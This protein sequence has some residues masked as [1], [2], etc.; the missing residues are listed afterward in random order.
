MT[1]ILGIVVLVEFIWL[2]SLQDSLGGLRFKIKRLEKQ[3][4]QNPAEADKPAAAPAREASVSPV[5]QTR[6]EPAH[7]DSA[8]DSKRQVLQ[9]SPSKPDFTVAKL[10]SWIGGFTLLLGVIFWIKYAIENDL[11][12]P[13][14]RIAASI[15][16]GVGLWTAGALIKK[17]ALKTTSDTLCASGLCICYAAWFSAYYFYQML[18]Q[19]AVFALLDLTALAAFGTAV[20]RRAKYIGFLA[21][22]IGFL[23]P[24][25]F[26]SDNPNLFFLLAYFAFVNA[27]AA[28]A[29]FTRKWDGQVLSSVAFTTLCLLFVVPGMKNIPSALHILMGF[30]LFFSALYSLAAFL[31]QKGTFLFA[32]CAAAALV[33]FEYLILFIYASS[34]GDALAAPF[35]VWAAALCVFFAL[36]PFAFKKRFFTDK[37]AWITVSAAGAAACL[38]ILLALY[39]AYSWDNGLIPLLFAVLYGFAAE[40][41]S[42]WQPLDEGIQRTRLTW[43]G[44]AAALFFTL[45]VVCQLEREWMT[46]ALAWEGCA[47]IWLNHKLG[48]TGLTTLG[49]WLLGAACVRLALNPAVLDYYSGG[50]KIFNWYLYAYGLSAAAMLAAA[51]GWLPRKDLG[52]VHFLQALAGVTLFAL[53]NIEIADYFSAGGTLKFELFGDVTAAAAYTVAW[54]VCGAVC[55]FL[56]LGDAKS[57]LHKA[58]LGL[59][60]AALAKLFLSDV[61]K[62]ETSARVIVLIGVAAI[63]MAV[64]FAYQQ[65][66]S[67]RRTPPDAEK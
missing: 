12:S 13:E 57:W 21:Q 34:Y 8:G 9:T 67:S 66:R 52:S 35:A 16:L 25:L 26:P 46:I 62:L 40:R 5:L 4:D 10:F 6:P 53:V 48:H 27:A 56:A 50:T 38:F 49:K 29:A 65:F 19:P 31:R 14:L 24:F 61:W 1:V 63:L 32:A 41:V 55:L 44:G 37:P 2:L 60:G 11:I 36:A 59:V 22:I 23:T 33:Q 58:G 43:L 64:S 20:W 28:A 54:A 45:A 47:L 18:S 17:P 3:L 7:A 15:L 42:R 51:R 39:R 30:T